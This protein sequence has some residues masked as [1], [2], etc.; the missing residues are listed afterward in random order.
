MGGPRMRA[1]FPLDLAL[2]VK[3]DAN[4]VEAAMAAALRERCHVSGGLRLFVQAFWAVVEP[5]A[6][7]LPGW[8]LDAVCE[9]LE[10]WYRR[11]FKD[12]VL[13]LPPGTG[14]SLLVDVFFPAWVWAVEPGHKFLTCSYDL[15]LGIRDADKLMT[16]I[17]AT[18]I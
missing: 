10:A 4:S 5:A 3:F 16:E 9:F 17:I 11:E 7:F 13:N 12:G 2:G 1:S 8:H 15:E 14:K 6:P 18:P